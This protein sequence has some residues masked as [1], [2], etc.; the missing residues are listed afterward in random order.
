[1]SQEDITSPNPPSGSVDGYGTNGYP[2]QSNDWLNKFC[3]EL[4]FHNLAF[5][6]SY[7][8]DVCAVAAATAAAT[9]TI[10]AETPGTTSS[11]ELDGCLGDT[12]HRIIKAVVTIILEYLIDKKKPLKLLKPE[13]KTILAQ[14]LNLYGA[15]PHLQRIQGAVETILFE[16]KDEMYIVEHLA[17]IRQKLVDES[18]EQIVYNAVD[19]WKHVDAEN[20]DSTSV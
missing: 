6:T 5:L 8:A 1:M 7:G 3:T 15:T 11:D 9:A 14:A 18:C 17:S 16:L 20:L 4:G 10:A 2:H 12:G 13:L 19:N